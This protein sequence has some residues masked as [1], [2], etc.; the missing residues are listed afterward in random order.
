MRVMHGLAVELR[1]VLRRMLAASRVSTTI[2]PAVIEIV[3]H[4]AV[5]SIP[6]MKPRTG[7]DEQAARIPFRAVIAVWS[8]VVRGLFVISVRAFWC[9]ADL[10]ANLRGSSICREQQQ[11]GGNRHPCK[12]PEFLHTLPRIAELDSTADG[13]SEVSD[14]RPYIDRRQRYVSEEPQLSTTDVRN[15]VRQSH[16]NHS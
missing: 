2:A 4:M 5:E 1:P 8:A 16:G 3:I 11:A 15:E 7:P 9:S 6:P 13:C 10:N 14:T 12:N